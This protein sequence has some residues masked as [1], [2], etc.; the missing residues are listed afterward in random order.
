MDDKFNIDEAEINKAK[1]AEEEAWQM[2]RRI[3]TLESYR[4]YMD[5]YPQGMY[6]EEARQRI[7]DIYHPVISPIVRELMLNRNAYSLA[8]LK[9]VGI[10]PNDLIEKIRDSKGYYREEVLKSWNDIPEVLLEDA[11]PTHLPKGVPEIYVWGL[12]RSGK[13]C[14]LAAILST[15]NMMGYLGP[16]NGY[17]KQLSTLFIPERNKF[18][19]CLPAVSTCDPNRYIPITLNEKVTDRIGR[20]ILK[21]HNLSVIEISGDIFECFSREI[22]GEPI[23]SNHFEEIYRQLKT[24]LNSKDNPKYHFFILDGNQMQNPV[25]LDYWHR[26]AC[27]FQKEGV[28]NKATL[29]MSLIVTKSDLLSPNRSEWVGYAKNY[30]MRYYASFVNILKSIV[31]PRGLG[32]T[33]GKFSVIPFSIGEVFFQDLCLFDPE[34]VKV[35]L[36]FLMNYVR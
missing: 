16:G 3:D 33:D 1:Q 10:T 36:D 27:Y 25:Q 29:G 28:F 23:M 22:Q 30:I 12:P 21:P 35:L 6:L 11:L 19:V 4:D 24:F 34:S 20:N 8:Y 13:T 18:A 9:A 7:H 32:L 14:V 31:G 17:V 5:A 26:A 2:A 15:A